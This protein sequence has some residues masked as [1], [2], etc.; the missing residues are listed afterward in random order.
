MT[1][2]NGRAAEALRASLIEAEQLREANR[3][4]RMRAEEPIAIIGMS[5]RYPGEVSSPRDLWELVASERDAISEFPADRG[6]DVD[7]VY[8]PD[9]EHRGTSYTRRGGFLYDAGE[10]DAEF[11]G[12]SPREALATDPQQ[13]LLLEGAWEAL[14]DGGID[15]A[16]LRGSQTG[17]FA[18]V[19]YQDYGLSAGPVPP[20]LESYMGTSVGGGVI[21]GRMAYTFGLEG[22]TV[23][24]DTA[25]SSS[26]V[27]MHLACQA[28]RQ[29]ECGLALAG[30]ITVMST[31]GVFIALSRQRALAPDGRCKT[32][33][34][35]AD[36]T[37]W[38]EGMG[39]VV[40]ER[41]SDARRLGHRPLALIRGSAVNQDG[42][43]NGLTAPNGPSQVRVIRQALASASLSA[44]DVDVVEA[45][46]T[47]TALGDPIEA[48]A[49]IEAYGQ[50]RSGSPLWLGSVKSNIGHTQAAAGVAGVMKMVMA[51][52]HGMLPKSLH[53]DEPSSHIDWSDGEV[54]LLRNA[55]EW[56]A[57]ERPRRAGVSAFGIS[58]TN[59]HLILEEAPE[60]AD[61][62]SGT[63]VVDDGVLPF[64]LS[65]SS[66]EAL[67]AQAARLRSFLTGSPDV[68][69]RDVGG[70][71]ALHRTGLPERAVV[72]AS[73]RAGL[74]QRLDAL[75]Q[76]SETE[77]V[78]RGAARGRGRVAFVFSGQGCQ[79]E[80]MG[81]RLLETSAVFAEQLQACSVAFAPY[82][83]FSLQDVLRGQEGAPSL[84]RIEVLQ[85]VLFAVMVGLAALW[86]SAGVE[87]A[88]VVGH[89]QGEIAAAHVAGALSL[90]DAA[91]VVAVRSGLIARLADKGAMVSIAAS[92]ER[93]ASLVERFDGRVALAVANS[94]SSVVL[95]CER[96]V[97]DQVLSHCEAEGLRAREV[98]ATVPTHSAHVEVLREELLQ[99]LAEIEPHSSAVPFYSTVAGSLLDTA[100][101]DGEYWYRNL[102]GVVQF[103]KAT[104]DLVEVGCDAF[105]EVSPH[106]VLGVAV[107][108]TLDT[109][110]GD[111]AVSVLGSLRRAEGGMERFLHSLAQAYVGGIAVDWSP[112]FAGSQRVGLPTYA[113]QRRRFWL[114]AGPRAGDASSLG[115]ATAEHPLLGGAV[116][117]AGDGEGMLFTGR[118]S[119]E[120]HPW[121]RDHALGD[122]PLLP[123][124]A[125]L[126]LALAAGQRVGLETLEELVLERPLIFAEQGAVQLQL[127]LAARDEHGR[128]ELAIYS[129]PDSDSGEEEWTRHAS[130]ILGGEGSPPAAEFEDF[131][132]SWPPP[133]AVELDTEFLYDRLAEAGYV[134]G[135]AFQG[136]RQAW[137]A[138][139]KLFVDVSLDEDQ[140]QQADS[141][142]IHP[143]LFD[144]A[145]HALVLAAPEGT[146]AEMRVPFSFTGMQLRAQGASVLRVCIS[147]LPE[148]S[149]RLVALDP[150]GAPVFSVEALKTRPIDQDVLRDIPRAGD[151]GLFS[152]HWTQLSAESSSAPALPGVLLADADWSAPPAASALGELARYRDLASLQAALDQGLPSPGLILVRAVMLEE[153]ENG[154]GGL[155][156]AACARTARLLE[157][158]QA[159]LAC[160]HLA[161]AKLVLLTE[162][163]LA[164]GDGEAPDLAQ[165]AFAGLMRSAH[166]EHPGRFALLDIDDS[167]ASWQ[168][169]G[170]ALA[171]EERELALRDGALHA[172]RLAR[173]RTPSEEESRGPLDTQGTVLIT[174]GTGGLGALLARHLVTAH[175]ARS[176]L[177]LSRSGPRA[178]GASELQAELEELGAQVR[179]VACD[180]AEKAQ[181][182]RV[183]DEIPEES[184][185]SAV[186][187][188]AGVLDDGLLSSLDE[189]R[190]E[191]V[192]APKVNAAVNLH[193]LT[194]H[195]GLSDFVL[196]SSA[197]A[198]LGSPG[199]GNYAAANAFLDALAEYRRAQ[200]LPGLSLAWGAWEMNSGMTAALSDADRARFTRLGVAA[201]ADT[202][203]LELFDAARAADESW[204][205]PMPMDAGALRAQARA[206]LLPQLFSSLVRTPTRRAQGTSGSLAKK[207]AAAPQSEW[208]Q[209]TLQAVREHVA[210]VLGYASADAVEPTRSFKELGFD[211]LSAIELRNRL[212]QAAGLRLPSTLIF[213]HPTPQASAA[214]LHQQLKQ[215]KPQGGPEQSGDEAGTLSELIRHAHDRGMLG[216]VPR[217]LVE[218]SIF[219]PTFESGAQAAGL[220]RPVTIA[221]GAETPELIGV[222]SFV[223]G[224]GPYQFLRIARAFDE[225]RAVAALSLPG[226]AKD[227]LLPGSWRVL[228]DMLAELALQTAA[229]KPFVLVGYSIGGALAHALAE[230]LQAT[231]NA[232]SGVVLLD[233]HPL[234]LDQ[235]PQI[236]SAVMSRILTSNYADVV[237]RD[238]HLVAMGA[239]MRLLSEWAPARLEIPSLLIQASE[240]LGEGVSN[241]RWQH[242][243][244]ATEVT[245][246]HFTIIEEQAQVTAEAIET[247]LSEIYSPRH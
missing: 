172:L 245:G 96:G 168:A 113:F 15:P 160:E 40:L 195:L 154:A 6:W 164:V 139:E 150:Q 43:S 83:D 233:T 111:R 9:P 204:L 104:R 224:M 78:V 170:G 209:I 148:E 115:L 108:E 186:I 190:L 141:F 102:R 16:T 98:P 162:G 18:G 17:V 217:L 114:S 187:H 89:S 189:Q 137:S 100:G 193:E 71:L 165:A 103:E 159:F 230:Q 10:F 158:L 147:P 242:A 36:G 107:E 106:P 12:I 149:L 241:E 131:A 219:R 34:E 138:G 42:A 56:P 244:T 14:E 129:R 48:G 229:G 24:I 32:F 33:A 53:I 91:R 196:Y 52:R 70:S 65:A 218:A 184:P 110:G 61:E 235:Q 44:G 182:E 55:V 90:E 59:A 173:F 156:R 29:G 66:T 49:L 58:G 85:P 144:S 203:G 237:V 191:R 2:D 5:C 215:A 21:S 136:L 161:A 216:D 157:L 125:F 109:L 81:A 174:G 57:G 50:G 207:L 28:L 183:L 101:L 133:G 142:V 99:G 194:Q 64:V 124:T 25:C 247:W 118:L 84:G 74:L 176:L 179:I 225:R 201:I 8:D 13:R 31:P 202:Q 116:D 23:T 60:L 222:P 105:L 37:G 80:G 30:G 214:F 63:G 171:S 192:F 112:F 47:G 213:D 92:A 68:G 45:H 152:V 39:L 180:A 226:F 243:Q 35:S 87:P 76:G 122:L 11:F 140:Q 51:M 188:A 38:S 20:E 185:L 227:E 119:L 228:V 181:L 4:L 86:R 146:S 169:L 153:A 77:G 127:T 54:D 123:G 236:F 62:I 134:Y 220:S 93:G 197:A 97:I 221:T 198:I 120:S 22:P 3:R 239:Y 175:G 238:D 205:A 211:S 27:A 46:G 95:A 75:A 240:P 132:G 206:G 210:A 177:L 88:F 223:N 143:A 82:L 166:S 69:S 94:P 72:I 26:L 126:D 231:D 7:R 41:L 1:V 232:A 128:C 130:G 199:Q 145:L 79:W 19:M 155:A 234:A 212:A 117:L 178:E 208:D 163:A 246:D 151:D 67:T 167:D 135:P 73:D 121:L 200:G